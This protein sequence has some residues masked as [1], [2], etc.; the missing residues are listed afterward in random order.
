MDPSAA[1]PLLSVED[2]Y[3]RLSDPNTILVDCRYDLANPNAAYGRYLS[4]HLPRSYYWDLGTDLSS[5]VSVHGGRHPLP[6]ASA[7]RT[8]IAQIGINVATAVIAYD[9]GDGSGATR[10]WWLLKYFGH[11]RA[12]VMNGGLSEWLRRGFQTSRD[13]PPMA[14]TPGN[15]ELHPDP[16]LT[17]DYV[18][19]RR[20]DHYP[21]VLIDSRSPERY[22]G[23]FEPIDV[24]AGHI[25]GALSWDYRLTQSRPGTYHPAEWL[26][27]YFRP[28]AA[29][30]DRL[31]V[32]CGSGVTATVNLLALQLAG[33][34]AR[35]Y[36]GGW[37]DW[38]SY[39]D[40]PVA[41]G[42]EGSRW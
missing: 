18:S 16:T 39:S 37:S 3:E 10:C 24:K 9:D 27:D 36:P 41:T 6:E 23:E 13:V 29:F 5:R 22:R 31:V 11:D 32:Y 19:L 20:L 34:S 25:P 33:I 40:A 2:V 15:I 17:V 21:F 28:L 1:H 42:G 8:L 26:Q 30:S 12:Y 4:A 38:V 14:P 7:F 35:L